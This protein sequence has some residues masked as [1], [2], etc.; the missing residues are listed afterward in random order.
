MRGDAGGESMLKNH[1]KILEDR[2][3]DDL[4]VRGLGF[5]IVFRLAHG[6]NS[7]IFYILKFFEVDTNQKLDNNDV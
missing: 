6:R 5:C 2:G 3:G 7:I 1:R 4:S